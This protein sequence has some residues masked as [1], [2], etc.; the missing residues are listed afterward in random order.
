M[1]ELHRKEWEFEKYEACGNAF[2]IVEALRIPSHSPKE[3]AGWILD[4]KRG[5]GGDGF[6][7]LHPSSKADV[8]MQYF[9]PDGSEAEICGNAL[10]SIGFYLFLKDRKTVHRIETLAGV[11][12]TEVLKSKGSWA[13]V[14]LNLGKPRG[15][16]VSYTPKK[17]KNYRGYFTRM[18][19]NPHVV[20]FGQIPSDEEFLALGPLIERDPLFPERTNVNFVERVEEGVYRLRPWERGTGETLSCATGAASAFMIGLSE[21]WMKKEVKFIFKGGE[22][23]LKNLEGELMIEGWVHR[24]AK[25][26]A[27]PIQRKF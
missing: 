10:R 24:V 25:G 19:G 13:W 20:L 9:N 21:G 6:I 5:L 22:L 16:Y 11:K 14:K 26:V 27:N 17:G 4:P 15:G 18:P 23:L 1:T 7:L 8:M 3:E 2:L 12:E